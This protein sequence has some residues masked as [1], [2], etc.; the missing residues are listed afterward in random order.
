MGDTEV[1][2]QMEAANINRAPKIHSVTNYPY[3]HETPEDI[4]GSFD[5]RYGTTD[6]RHQ[7]TEM[8]RVKTV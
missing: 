4:L 6:P 3:Q 7:V 1:A 5:N 2:R 8:D